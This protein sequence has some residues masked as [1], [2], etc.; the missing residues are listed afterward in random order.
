[1]KNLLLFIFILAFSWP[2]VA[3]N[4][5]DTIVGRLVDAK[6]KAI[7]KA[8]VSV[9][10]VKAETDRYGIFQLNNVSLRDI[11]TVILPKTEKEVQVSVNGIAYPNIA[12]GPEISVT[13][14]K[15][16]IMKLMLRSLRR[17]R[18]VSST[19]VVTGEELAATGESNLFN[20]LAGKV[21]GFTVVMKDNGDISAQLRGSTSIS[22]DTSPLYLLDGT[23]VERLDNVNINDIKKVEISKDSNMYGAKGANGVIAVTLK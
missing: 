13:E 20:A 6:G 22:L 11:L 9:K 10:D 16:E 8:L 19:I 7:R 4:S 21:P 5:N 12:L 15:G 17:S 23:Q 3:Q 1:M 18:S 14:D 2:V